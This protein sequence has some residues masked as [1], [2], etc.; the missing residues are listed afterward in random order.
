MDGVAIKWTVIGLAAAVVGIVVYKGATKTGAAV[1]QLATET[2]NPASDKNIVYGSVNAAGAA[3]TG[4]KD[5]TFGGWLASLTGADQND[6]IAAM[7]KGT[8]PAASYDETARLAKRYPAP[9]TYVDT[10][11][12]LGN[13]LGQW[14][15]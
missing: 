15:Q 11:D 13:Y 3:V 9:V 5:F 1:K 7:L 2:L 14:P 6:K 8:P 4:D 12:P 10:Y